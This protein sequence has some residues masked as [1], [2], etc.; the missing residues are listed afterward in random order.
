MIV[1]STVLPDW[2]TYGPAVV[3]SSEELACET[4]SDLGLSDR[5]LVYCT[6]VDRYDVEVLRGRSVLGYVLAEL[7]ESLVAARTV[8]D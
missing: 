6:V 4:V 3:E 2:P 8:E 7:V 1:R 5:E